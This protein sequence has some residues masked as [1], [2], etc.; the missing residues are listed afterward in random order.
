MSQELPYFILQTGEA[1]RGSLPKIWGFCGRRGGRF[2]AEKRALR[3]LSPR[4]LPFLLATAIRCHRSDCKS[5]HEPCISPR[6]GADSRGPFPQG[7]A[8]KQNLVRGGTAAPPR[9]GPC[10]SQERKLRVGRRQ[11]ACSSMPGLDC[12]INILTIM[13]WPVSPAGTPLSQ[14]HFMLTK[15]HKLWYDRSK[16]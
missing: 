6:G 7:I 12:N 16:I 9:R 11:S 3:N 4:N 2:F 13:I 1:K 10:P 5:L 8:E 15:C 14:A